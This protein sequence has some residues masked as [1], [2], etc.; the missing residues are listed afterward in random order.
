[1]WHLTKLIFDSAPYGRKRVRI[2]H[3]E[4]IIMGNDADEIQRHNLTMTYHPKA[5][6]EL[7]IRLHLDCHLFSRTFLH[8]PSTAQFVQ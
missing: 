4:V 2:G 6:D 1:M 8:N 3:W 5:K 7:C